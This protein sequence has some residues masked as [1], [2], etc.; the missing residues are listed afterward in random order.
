MKFYNSFL[1]KLSGLFDG[2]VV[3]FTKNKYVYLA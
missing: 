1:L 2:K 3:S